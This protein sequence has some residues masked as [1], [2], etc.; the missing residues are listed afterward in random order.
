[1]IKI[2]VVLLIILTS[3]SSGVCGNRAGLSRTDKESI[4]NGAFISY[5]KVDK[6]EIY[7]P[8]DSVIMKID[9]IYREYQFDIQDNGEI[10]KNYLSQ[11]II[12][13]N[14]S[15]PESYLLMWKIGGINEPNFTSGSDF[16]HCNL[17]GIDRDKFDTLRF[18][19][20]K[21]RYSDNNGEVIGE[22]TL[23][24]NKNINTYSH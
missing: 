12:K 1:M 2:N 8:Y 23:V 24:E 3:C 19:I 17:E 5:Y 10:V 7:N 18:A 13:M 11:L 21:G 15:I 6:N 14:D 4:K 22:L 16:L 20:V 9:N